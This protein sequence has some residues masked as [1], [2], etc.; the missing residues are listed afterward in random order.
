MTI[1]VKV[2][3][4]SARTELIGKMADGTLKI[5]IAAVPD[6]GRANEELCAFLAAQYG[7]SRGE[8]SIISGQTSALK[9]VRV[10]R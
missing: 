9:L 6:K 8:V 4:R 7:V 3:A 1:R 2:I 10:G 5:K